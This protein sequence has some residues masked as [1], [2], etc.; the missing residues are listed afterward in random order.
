MDRSSDKGWEVNG[1]LALCNILALLRWH[2]ACDFL[3]HP[4]DGS[5]VDANDNDVAG[6]DDGD[7]ESQNSDDTYMDMDE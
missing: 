3:R 2:D 6:N 7:D 1:A 5:D 4:S